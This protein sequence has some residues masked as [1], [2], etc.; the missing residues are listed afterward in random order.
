[1]KDEQK[2]GAYNAGSQKVMPV[3]SRGVEILEVGKREQV[4]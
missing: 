4:S 3:K 1:V 2:M